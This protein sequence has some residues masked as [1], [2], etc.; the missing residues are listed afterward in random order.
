[1]TPID[2]VWFHHGMMDIGIVRVLLDY[3]VPP[4][5]APKTKRYKAYIGCVP[6]GMD[7]ASA[8]G[9]IAHGGTRYHYPLV[10]PLWPS[11]P[12]DQWYEP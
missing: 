8:M 3:G 12:E 9:I 4:I 10:A 11:I 5:E 2:A 1:M 7:E 6:H